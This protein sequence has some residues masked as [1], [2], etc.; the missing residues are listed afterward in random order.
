MV[1]EIGFYYGLGNQMYNYAFAK[2][3]EH[4]YKQEVRL[5][6]SRHNISMLQRG[7]DSITNGD[8]ERERE[9]ERFAGARIIELLHFNISLKC[10]DCEDVYA[11]FK[12]YDKLNLPINLVMFGRNY[13]FR[14]IYKMLPREWRKWHYRYFIESSKESDVES[15]LKSGIYYKERD[16][17]R[18]Y[19]FSIAYFNEIREILLRDFSLKTPL[20]SKNLATKKHILSVKDSVFLHIRRGD[21]LECNDFAILGSS[22]YNAAL[23]IIKNAL[24]HATIFVFSNGIN[25]CKENLLGYLDSNITQGLNFEFIDN[26]HEGCAAFDLELMKSCKHAI[27]ANSTFSFWGAYLIENPSKIVVMPNVYSY[28]NPP[29]SRDNLKDGQKTWHIIDIYWG[30]EV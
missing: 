10:M 12:K 7:V 6:I 9:R 21:Y 5:D 29:L 17:F 22:Y 2:A 20:D 13:F 28:S 24:P 19:F 15:K 14:L 18:G 30:N 4:Y 27:I 25:W 8:N 26:N 23:K 16:Y 3:L 1:V 11:F